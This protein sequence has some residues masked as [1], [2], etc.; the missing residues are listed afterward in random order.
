MKLIDIQREKYRRVIPSFEDLDFNRQETLDEWELISLM[1]DERPACK[2]ALIHRFGLFGE[3]T[4]TLDQIANLVGIVSRETVRQA[5]AKA[6]RILRHPRNI[7]IYPLIHNEKLFY[8]ITG[9][10][11][12]V[13]D[14]MLN[15]HFIFDPR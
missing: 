15:N 1:G 8:F 4:K 11:T 3:K 5:E 9:G 6:L 2:V 7:W 12:N 10:Y 14:W 13:R